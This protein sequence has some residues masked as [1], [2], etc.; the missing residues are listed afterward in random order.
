M[1][2]IDGGYTDTADTVIKHI[3]ANYGANYFIN[4]M[5]LSHADNDHAMGLIG[6]MEHFDVKHLW[7]NRPW[8]FAAEIL[9]YMHGNYTL[10][11][12]IDKIREMHPYLIE[13]ERLRERKGHNHPRDLSR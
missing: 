4:N 7:M 13:L 11:G 5:I 6:V 1:H 8:L 3:Q 2:V 9:P 10:Q 12:L